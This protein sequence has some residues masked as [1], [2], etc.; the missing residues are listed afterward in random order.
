MDAEKLTEQQKNI[1][2]NEHMGHCFDYLRQ[3]LMCAGDTTLESA[4]RLPNGEWLPTVDGWGI[5]H[6]CRSWEE[7]IEWT[8]E[9]RAPEDRTGILGAQTDH[10]R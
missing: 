3:A 6:Q 8:L 5:I 10:H 1:S 4:Q 7:A 2:H 9:H